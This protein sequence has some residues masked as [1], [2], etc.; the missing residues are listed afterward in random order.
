VP[1]FTS[2]NPKRPNS[3]Q[4]LGRPQLGAR[5]CD[6]TRAK[7]E[8]T[9]IDSSAYGIQYILSLTPSISTVKT[10]SAY[11]ISVLAQS[12]NLS[13]CAVTEVRAVR[14]KL[15][16]QYHNKNKGNARIAYRETRSAN[17][18]RSRKAI[19]ITRSECLSE[20]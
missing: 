14:S 18:C 6:I 10:N 12:A 11:V 15:V 4:S 9:T 13:A 1:Q 7:S 5:P 20:A 2:L 19:S 17:H 16:G 8:C 3:C